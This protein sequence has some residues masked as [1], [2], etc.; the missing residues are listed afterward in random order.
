MGQRHPQEIR[1][2]RTITEVQFTAG[3]TDLVYMPLFGDLVSSTSITD[4]RVRRSFPQPG[5]LRSFTVVTE[6]TG[7][8][9]TTVG[10]HKNFGTSPVAT[11]ALTL[12]SANARY[13]FDFG[14]KATT[15]EETDIVHVSWN[16]A[17]STTATRGVLEWYIA[18][19]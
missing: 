18:A 7:F 11:A 16:P 17:A 8:G 2:E 9:V 12:S 13:H 1:L 6:G 3:T 15:F 19:D 10:L 4:V 5:K 14:P